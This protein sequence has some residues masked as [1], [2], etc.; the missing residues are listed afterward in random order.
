MGTAIIYIVCCADDSTKAGILLL[1][2]YAT[3][4]ANSKHGGH[5]DGYQV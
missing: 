5:M 1:F 4:I 2:Q 3:P